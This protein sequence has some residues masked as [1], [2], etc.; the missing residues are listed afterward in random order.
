MLIIKNKAK[1][2]V[3]FRDRDSNVPPSPGDLPTPGIKPRSPAL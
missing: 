2:R 3:V 1:I